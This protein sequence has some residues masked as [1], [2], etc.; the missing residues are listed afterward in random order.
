MSAEREIEPKRAAEMIRNGT[1]AIDVR[2]SD[3]YEAG[4]IEGARHVPFARLSGEAAG[5]EAGGQVIFYCRTGDRS[6]TAAA[7]FAESGVDAHN[8]AGG[9]EG[10]GGGGLPPRAGGRRGGAG[11]G[12]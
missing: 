1:P 2:D 12:P 9:L 4:H 3:E 5:V 8:I 6:S 7:A 10:L 11:G